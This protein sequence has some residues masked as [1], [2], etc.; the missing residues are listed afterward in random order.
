[1]QEFIT[2]K[3]LEARTHK[4]I[5]PIPM[6]SG[7]VEYHKIPDE[8]Y[9]SYQSLIDV[10]ISKEGIVKRA[11]EMQKRTSMTYPFCFSLC[12]LEFPWDEA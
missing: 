2:E 1:M 12:A 5:V 11:V 4:I 9:I 6:P 3:E 8:S 10:G 7:E